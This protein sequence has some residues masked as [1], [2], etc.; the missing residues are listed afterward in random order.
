[1]KVLNGEVN[2]PVRHFHH[3]SSVFNQNSTLWAGNA[4]FAYLQITNH[5]PELS[6][7]D[8]PGF[9]RFSRRATQERP[10][11]EVGSSFISVI[12]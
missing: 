1:M 2:R 3:I 8:R 6:G 7:P 5:N 11:N 10:G 9:F 12:P 4:T